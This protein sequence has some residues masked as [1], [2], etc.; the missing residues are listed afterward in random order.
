MHPTVASLRKRRPRHPKR[1]WRQE[2][3]VFSSHFLLTV[4]G[5]M[6]SMQTNDSM[7][8][9]EM[10]NATA[11]LPPPQASSAF[12]TDVVA[13]YKDSG[14]VQFTIGKQMKAYRYMG[15]DWNGFCQ[16]VQHTSTNGTLNKDLVLKRRD[17][18]Q[19][20]TAEVLNAEWETIASP[21][22]DGYFQ[23]YSRHVM[24]T[25]HGYKL[26]LFEAQLVFKG[27]LCTSLPC[28]RL[29]LHKWCSLQVPH[30]LVHRHQ[31]S[32]KD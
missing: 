5:T 24:T 26:L 12:A 15:T 1:T 18:I 22:Q 30:T 14:V 11:P 6:A 7:D 13:L 23:D 21:G 16:S 4:R 29:R 32:S 28:A 20:I 27:M 31:G 10:A 8:G 17:D 9:I 25:F 2:T 19:E 3:T